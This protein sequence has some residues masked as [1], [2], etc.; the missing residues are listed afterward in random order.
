MGKAASG[1]NVSFG[2]PSR[3]HRNIIRTASGHHRDT[4]ETQSG[5]HRDT[6]ETPSGHHRDTS[7]TIGHLVCDRP[8]AEEQ[9]SGKAVCLPPTPPTPRA[10][11]HARHEHET[12]NSLSRL[13]G[14]SQR[15]HT[16]TS[17]TLLAC[18]RR[19]YIPI[20]GP[21]SAWPGSVYPYIRRPPGGGAS[22]II[23]RA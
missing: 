6:I 16:P 7:G 8:P 15:L 11:S 4:I 1:S 19:V 21:E 18:G 17:N 2:T 14:S 23:M 12:R 22:M 9:E 13:G 5:H 20:L 3:H 10:A